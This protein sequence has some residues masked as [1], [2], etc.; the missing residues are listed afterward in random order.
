MAEH[1]LKMISDYWFW[2]MIGF[3]AGSTLGIRNVV[4][5]GTSFPIA[6]IGVTAAIYS[7]F[8]GARALYVL[9]FYPEMFY[10]NLPLALAF[11][12]ETGTWLGAP[13]LGP[14]LPF[15]VVTATRQPFWSN[16]GSFVPGLAL[17]HVICRIGCLFSG[18]CYGS[19][20]TVPWAIYSKHLNTM[21]HP[22]QIYSMAGEIIAFI[23][24]QTLWTKKPE[25]RK[26]LY[27]CY[28]LM[29]GFHRF[30]SEFFRGADAGPEII[31][32]LRV[33][34]IVCIFI[35]VAS[36]CVIV[37]LKWKKRGAVISLILMAVPVFA[38]IF[39]PGT[40]PQLIESRHNS[41]LFLVATRTMFK[42]HL[43]E[44]KNERIK[45]GFVVVIRDWSATPSGNEIR[46]WIRAQTE[47]SG[48][49]CSY[50]M[51]VGDCAADQEVFQQYHIPSIK[52]QF[53]YK[54]KT[55]EFPSD[56]LYGD[57]DGDGCPEIPVGRLT[58]QNTIELKSHI[59]K[60]LSYN[61]KNIKQEAVIWI[62]AKNY[63]SGMHDIANSMIKYLPEW[64]K[65]FL[66]SADP[67]S[68]K[69]DSL[70][71]QPKVFLEQISRPVFLSLI[72]AHGSYRSVTTAI[73]E[74][75]EVFLCVEDVAQLKS[76]SPTGPLF[77]LSCSSGQFNMPLSS[78][79]SLAEAFAV[80]PGGPI[81][82]V[83][84]ATKNS[85]L[86]NYFFTAEMVALLEKM[87]ETIGDSLLTIQRRLFQKGGPSLKEL[88]DRDILAKY[89]VQA[90]PEREQ[91]IL[92]I[93][94]FLQQEVLM[95]NLIG[96]PSCKIKLP[97]KK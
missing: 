54:N 47:N 75:K 91:H 28:G 85:P 23:V 37:T 50:I 25:I 13:I 24:L 36:L 15:I 74:G 51:L 30:F 21:V 26:Y 77:L 60:I 35:F 2:G 3:L 72:A 84:A 5:N 80:H 73:H 68:A 46:K 53:Q 8:F 58:V 45:E 40:E 65:L 55:M 42:N 67:R 10:I 92:S 90:V 29:L 93:P 88:A 17:A 38:I 97:E 79:P 44:W 39:K 94:N 83:A 41:K 71:N 66:I 48:G 43:T 64:M 59:A 96:D 7:G 78:G 69:G 95:Y 27:P 33:F 52:H 14:L 82:V 57:I 89:L 22:T 32:G 63:T 4:K 62:G 18:C 87:P 49:L 61:K 86:S 9:I 16:L 19:P 20:T 11:W 81:A 34:Q 1:I 12:Q 31:P 70:F 56:N 6:V 76:H